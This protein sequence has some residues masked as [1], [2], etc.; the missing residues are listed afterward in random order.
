MTKQPTTNALPAEEWA[1]AMGERW[2]NHLD[3]FESMIASIGDALM[4]RAGYRPGERVVDVGC[5]GGR[6][7]LEIARR[8][9]PTGAV[10]GVD[11]SP[12]LIAAARTLVPPPG[13]RGKLSFVG[14]DAAIA[15]LDGSPFD[16]LFSRFGLMFFQD[17]FAAFANL[18]RMVRRGGRADFS[19]WSPA[20]ENPWLMQV[21][22]I[23]G[24]RVELPPPT[25]RAPGPFALDD[26]DY[27]RDLLGRGGFSD[28]QIETWSGE[29]A[30]GGAGASPDQAVTFV[31]DAMSLGR[32]L[33]DAG[34]EVL[35]KVKVEL[36]DLFARHHTD[37][38]VKMA[39]KAFLVSAIA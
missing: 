4:T 36:R 5:G 32:T 39:A 37:A 31:L 26:P 3:Q 24:R 34:P 19:V 35:A 7:S 21:M 12:V 23:I 22:G 27:I 13:E 16:G 17:P 14:A 29:Q 8:V 1:G 30:I 18:H 6:T 11:I 9:G 25:P 20:R 33:E 28:V 38:G 15:T 10:L 2:L